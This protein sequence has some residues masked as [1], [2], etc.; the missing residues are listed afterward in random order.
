MARYKDLREDVAVECPSCPSYTIDQ[1]I[2]KSAV[3]FFRQSMAWREELDPISL[4]DAQQGYDLPVNGSVQ[5][6]KIFEATYSDDNT[7]DRMLQGQQLTLLRRQPTTETAQPTAFTHDSFNQQI[8]VWHIPGA[9]EVVD[10]A[11][12]TVSAALKPLRSTRSIPDVLMEEWRDFLVAGALMKLK[13]ITHKP[14]FDGPGARYNHD[15]FYN[16]VERARRDANSSS[17]RSMR[18]TMRPFR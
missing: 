2:Q 8:L 18:V 16:G 11:F 14:W 1:E 5:V 10:S 9:E 6:E 3:E 13:S 12:L 4:V 7:Q 17:G 15:L